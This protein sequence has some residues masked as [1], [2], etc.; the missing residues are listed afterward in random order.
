[1]QVDE[2]WR[3]GFSESVDGYSG[4]RFSQV[5]DCFD[6]ISLD[7]NVGA[8]SWKTASV[9]HYA[10]HDLDV[11]HLLCLCDVSEPLSGFYLQS[12][13]ITICTLFGWINLH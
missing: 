12:W 6:G 11:E 8:D 2:S 3:H 5:A 13:V 4:F 1:M 10:S 9:V 7:P